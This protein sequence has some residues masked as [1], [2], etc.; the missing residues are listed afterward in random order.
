MAAFAAIRNT[1]FAVMRSPSDKSG[2]VWPEEHTPAACPRT[3]RGT[4]ATK[5]ICG[6]AQL[7]RCDPAH[8]RRGALVW[9]KFCVPAAMRFGTN[10]ANRNCASAAVC[11]CGGAAFRRETAPQ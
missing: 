3:A 11:G 9:L 4:V 8:R 5:H 2:R 1:S 6:R 10:A 7:R